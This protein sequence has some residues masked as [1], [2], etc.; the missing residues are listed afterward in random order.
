MRCGIKKFQVKSL[1]Q[2]VF[3]TKLEVAYLRVN[4]QDKDEI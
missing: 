2:K 3:N 1:S 4:S